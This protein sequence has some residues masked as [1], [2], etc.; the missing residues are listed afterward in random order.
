M[1]TTNLR[2]NLLA[3]YLGQGWGAIANIAFI[4]VYI[5]LLG[6]ES[7]GLIGVFAVI[8]SAANLADGGMA[9]TL[10]REMAAYCAGTRSIKYIKDLMLTVNSLCLII[11]IVICII[12]IIMAPLL[13]TYWM[14]QRALPSSVVMQSLYLMIVVATLRVIEGVQRGA[15]L[16]LHRHVLL[17]LIS[18][19][20]VTFRAV[21]V[22]LPLAFISPTPQMFFAWQ[23]GVSAL[24]VV[25]F[26]L[27]VYASISSEGDTP[28]FK[29]DIVRSLGAFAGGVLGAT[30]LGVVLTQADKIILVKLLPLA[31]FSSYALATAVAGGLYQ[32]VTPVAQSFYPVLTSRLASGDDQLATTYHKGS[33]LVSATVAP[34][35]A[36]LIF[37]ATPILTFWTGN[38][39]MAAQAAPVMS[40][41]AL[42]T[43]C[44][45]M[46]YMPYMLQLAAG[47]S[48][49]AMRMNASM[50]AIVFPTMLMVVPRF[51]M[52]GAAATWAG[53]NAAALVVTIQ[54]MHRRL[55]STEM[56]RWYVRDLGM[57]VAAALITATLCRSIYPEAASAPVRLLLLAA[58]CAFTLLAACLATPFVQQKLG[59]MLGRREYL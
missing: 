4:P 38:N 6:V 18:V 1:V 5:R 37:F 8:L 33:Q 51:G 22:V 9:A 2:V 25:G 3:N 27:A 35:A 30:A 42:G 52:I 12:A 44:H 48:G 15:L 29:W 59:A 17:N 46:M 19:V 43:M 34:P 23:A 21:G 32:I 26:G 39:A 54:I 20:T 50:V 57:P 28:A 41:L 10:N 58:S 24:S 49:L 16:G 13:A 7:F 31:Q 55:L 56:T 45:C 47:W 53:L 36:I 11:F 40:L 14:G